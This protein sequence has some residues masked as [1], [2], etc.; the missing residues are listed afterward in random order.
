M[1]RDALR[2]AWATTPQDRQTNRAWLTRFLLSMWPQSA[3][4]CEVYAGSTYTSA[5]PARCTAIFTRAT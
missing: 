3:Q 4:V 5:T 2:S 1:L